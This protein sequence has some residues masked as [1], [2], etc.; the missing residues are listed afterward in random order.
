MIIQL[1]GLSGAGKTTLSKKVEEK[2]TNAGEAVAIIDGDEYRKTLNKDLGFSKQDRLE[3]IRRLGIVAGALSAHG[4]TAIIGAINPYEE[5]RKE[6][7]AT[8]PNVKTVYID[9]PVDTLI[10]RDTKG[11]YKRAALP[12]EH[13]DKVKNLTGINDGFDVPANP[14][15]HLDTG[16]QSIDECA[17]QLFDFILRN[18]EIQKKVLVIVGMHRS[19]TSMITQWLYKSGFHLG[20]R[21]LGAAI[22]NAEGHFEDL[23]FV[24]FH[25]SVLIAQGLPDTGLTDKPIGKLSPLEKEKIKSIIAIKSK[26]NDEWGWKDPRTCLFLPLYRELIPNAVYV[27]IVRDFASSVSSL[28]NRI[29][30]KRDKKNRGAIDALIWKKIKGLKKRKELYQELAEQYLKVWIAYNE[31]ILEHIKVLPKNAYIVVDYTTLIK[32]D[33]P[34]FT[35]LTKDWNLHLNYVDFKQIYNRKLITE[36]Q[37]IDDYINDKSLLSKAN[38]LENQL[39]SFIE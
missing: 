16:V 7:K 38:E 20:E 6:M 30:A 26:L 21:I 23:D 5:A 39:R 34:I 4:V 37:K 1:C 17:N 2:L 18:K 33:Q 12:D 36:D 25:E 9:C 27:I 35:H 28:I 13:P 15:L 32:N 29:F 24:N 22:G 31:A 8:Y 10:S 3:N 14:D 11:L 19:G